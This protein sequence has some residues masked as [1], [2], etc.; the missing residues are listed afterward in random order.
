MYRDQAARL[1]LGLLAILLLGRILSAAAEIPPV[2]P[3]FPHQHACTPGQLLYRQVDLGRVTNIIYHNGRVYAN[4]V[5]NNPRR[6]WLFTD[7]D[8]PGSFTIV[9][10]TNLPHMSS[11]GNHAHTKSGDYAGGAG[12]LRFRRISPGVN[13]N[14]AQMPPEDRFNSIQTGPTGGGLHNLYY[15]W[16][17]PFNWIQYGPNAGAARLWR[18]ERLLAE[19]QPLAD[20]GVAGNSILLGNVLFVISDGSML[21]V[22]AYHISP[23][24]ADP[25]QP[26]ALL[27]KFTGPVGAYIGA[28]WENYLVL[29]GGATDM[30]KVFVIDIEDPTDLRLAATITLTHTPGWISS[31]NVPYVQTQDEF[32]FTRRHKINMETLSSVLE[33]DEVGDNRPAGSVAGAL[34]VSQYTLPLGNLLISGSY[35]FAGRDGVGVWCH[36]AAPDT[37]AP[38]IGYHVPRPGQTNFPLGAPIS[39]VI[40]E[41][42]ESFTIVNGE[43]I[44]VRPVGGQP[45][46]ART[47]FSHDGILTVT[48]KEYLADDTTYEVVIPAG[49]IKDVSGNGIQGYS[50]TFSTGGSVGGGNEAPLIT[51]LTASATPVDP[52]QPVQFGVVASDPESDPLQYRFSFGGG[53]AATSW[54]TSPTVSRTFDNP[55]HYEVKAQVR[56][57][58]PDGTSS[59][60]TRT[61]TLTVATMPTGPLPTHSSQMAL[62]AA[63]RR[64]WV[65]DPD[66]DVVTS[67]NADTRQV[68]RRVVLGSVL[69]LPGSMG[70][71]S[72]AVAPG[73]QVWVTL[74]DADRVAVLSPSGALVASIDTGFGSSPQAVS[75]SRDGSRAFVT[76]QARGASDPGN[77]QLVRFNTAT[78]SE[79]GRLELGPSARAIALTGNGSRAFVARFVSREHFGEVWDINADAMTLT[80]TLPLWRDRG[81]DGLDAGGSDGPGVPNYVASLV[82]SPQQ[83]WLWYTAI[84][85]DT[86]RGEF[87]RQDTTLNLPLAHDSTVR[88]ILGRIDLLHTSGTP[89]EPGQ[90]ASGAG[91]GRIDVDNSDSPSALVFSPRG[92]YVFTALQGNNTV[93]VF[94]DLAIRTGGGR[95][96]IWRLTSGAAPQALLWDPH[97][98]VIWARNFLDRSVHSFDLSGFIATGSRDAVAVTTV[99]TNLE[100]LPPD[101]LAGKRT[102]YFAGNAPDGHNQMSFEGYIACASCHIDGGQDARV[103]DFTQR[104]E[105]FRNTTDL[106]GRA[107]MLQGN[108]HWTG[109]FD[110]IEDFVIDIVEEFRGLGFLP[111][112]QTPNPPLGA[113]NAGR[114]VELDQLAEYVASLDSLMLPRSPHRQ[115]GGAFSTAAQQG[116][117]LF[118]STG[119]GNCHV[120]ARG[121]TDSSLGNAT[122]HNVG[123]LRTSSGQRLGQTLTGIDTPTLLGVWETAPYFHDGSAQTLA[124]V[125]TVAGGRMY[126]A[127]HAILADGANVPT[128]QHINSDSSAHGYL[129]SLTQNG[130][131]VTFEGVDGGSGG[132]GAVELR[133]IPTSNA[134]GTLVGITVNGSHTQERQLARIIT[135][136]EWTRVRFENVP[137][138]A[139]SNNLIQV[140]RVQSPVHPAPHIDNITVSTANDLALAA[141]HRA[142]LALSETDRNRLLAYVRSLDGR[143]ADGNPVVADL[144]FANGFQ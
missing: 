87:F 51:E 58:K 15:P 43:S 42:L 28:I 65:V 99:T 114:S 79:T 127:E 61:M 128:F 105:G 35:S 47:S 21:G 2:V 104:G 31:S 1:A 37:R 116:A 67:V 56:D 108:V 63:N 90:A 25:P 125:F 117:A 126:E 112:G 48:P 83:D 5:A 54:G 30:N 53:S 38:Y 59:V 80:R 96:S 50:F 89:Q 52:G 88:S 49:G 4:N 36:Q 124:D 142:A 86:F 55:G 69:G 16:A 91:R 6:E 41:E 62:D 11:Q 22:A 17:T 66:N 103:W 115:A 97:N 130:A 133:F 143:D 98:D 95:S 137:L 123:T 106:R 136:N 132:N 9:N 81:N 29:S 33:L 27:D 122:L 129:V 135:R 139:G 144:I 111:E 78:R 19:W 85:M 131:S 45:V 75:I 40:A 141:P 10:T 14:N 24:F 140:R 3:G 119:C 92:D 72:V 71:T 32:V 76:L 101:V 110:E 94:D 73:G 18:A 107:G 34:E 64:V 12:G 82:L 118:S 20:H 60:V 23:V 109:N 44:I 57:I 100:L 77:G 84:K 113:P 74:R 93:A 39:L 138:S 102:F 13:D 68:A 134:A 70:P 46:D 120:P 26:P 7:V 121:F 8:D